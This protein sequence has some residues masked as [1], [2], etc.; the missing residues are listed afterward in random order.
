MIFF[1]QALAE[2]ER[3]TKLKASR[4]KEL[5]MKKRSELEYICCK[6]HIQ[7][8]S[9][10]AAD[11]TNAMIDSGKE[12]HTHVIVPFSQWTTCSVYFPVQFFAKK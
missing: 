11:K 10:T 9:S 3:L 7:P 8:D 2:I 6:N 4:M 5:V 1:F 12:S